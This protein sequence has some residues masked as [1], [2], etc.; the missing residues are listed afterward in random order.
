MAC[1]LS[2]TVVGCTGFVRAPALGREFRARIDDTQ[3]DWPSGPSG[4]LPGT[5]SRLPWGV[6][7]G[8]LGGGRWNEAGVP[9][10]YFAETASVAVREM[11]NYLPSPRLV[12]FSYRLGI[13]EVREDMPTDRWPVADLPPDWRDFP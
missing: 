6:G 12:P 2:V 3:P 9:A 1:H 7:A 13:F 10:L 11:A 8:Y 4:G 5:G